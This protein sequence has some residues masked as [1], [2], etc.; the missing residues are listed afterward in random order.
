MAIDLPQDP[1]PHRIDLMFDNR[2]GF[3]GGA[4]S[5]TYVEDLSSQ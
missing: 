3:P 1:D 4:L 5:F 2:D